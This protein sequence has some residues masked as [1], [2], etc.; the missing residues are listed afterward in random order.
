MVWATSLPF[1][2]FMIDSCSHQTSHSREETRSSDKEHSGN[3]MSSCFPDC[4]FMICSFSPSVFTLLLHVLLE[5]LKLFIYYQRTIKSFNVSSHILL[6]RCT[7]IWVCICVGFLH[8]L[9]LPNSC[10]YHYLWY[11]HLVILFSL[12]CYPKSCEQNIWSHLFSTSERHQCSR[13]VLWWALS[14]SVDIKL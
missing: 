2:R 3:F 5:H 8:E 4:W 14:V 1:S 12:H 11:V 6:F 10:S 9:Q 7:F 13:S